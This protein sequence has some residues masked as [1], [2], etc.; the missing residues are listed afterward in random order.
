MSEWLTDPKIIELAQDR[1]LWDSILKLTPSAVPETLFN[2]RH[3]YG[4]LEK[5]KKTPTLDN[6]S[7]LR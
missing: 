6:T 5:P 7:I 3:T 4:K 2:L 1:K